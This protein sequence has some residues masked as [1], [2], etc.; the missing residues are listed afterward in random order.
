MGDYSGIAWNMKKNKIAD[1]EMGEGDMGWQ[2][3]IQYWELLAH[4]PV[5]LEGLVI[6]TTELEGILE[7]KRGMEGEVGIG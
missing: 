6:A 3:I 7:E 5:Q 1:E 4:N 2:W